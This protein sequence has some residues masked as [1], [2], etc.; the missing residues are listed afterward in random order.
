MRPTLIWHPDEKDAC[1]DICA[2]FGDPPCWEVDPAAMPCPKCRM[3]PLPEP[4]DPSAVIAPM[5]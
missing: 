4:L 1:A 2:G 5:L 3:T